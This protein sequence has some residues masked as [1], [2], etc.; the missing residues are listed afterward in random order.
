MNLSE[1]AKEL[2]LEAQTL[3]PSTRVQFVSERCGADE[4]LF[5]E[6][7][8]LLEASEQSETYF[9][10]LSS[11]VSL[12]SLATE[13]PPLPD[14]KLIGHWRLVRLLGRG[15][16]GTVYLAERSDDQFE[17]QA[18]LKLLPFGVDSET[19]RARFLTERQILASLA[20]DNIARLLDGGVTNEGTPYFVMDYV[21]G[22][23]IDEYCA[24][25]ELTLRKRLHLILDVA[26]AVQFAHR[27]LIVH[28]DLKPGNVLVEKSGQVKLLDFGIAKV[29]EP[30]DEPS[31]ATL[32]AQRPVTPAFSSP[33]MLSGAPV[34]VTTDVYSIGALAYLLLTGRR[35]RDPEYK[36]KAAAPRS[37]VPPA[38]ALTPDVS[39]ELDAVL[40]KALAAD[41]RDRYASVEALAADV[42]NYLS[43]RP[44]AAKPASAWYRGRKFVARNRAA[45]GLTAIAAVSLVSIALLSAQ[46]AL[47]SERQAQQIALERDRA[48]E[49]KRFLIEIFSS[50]DPNR[51]ASELTAKELLDAGRQRIA[52]ELADQPALQVD[53]LRAMSDVYAVTR[54]VEPWREALESE[55]RLREALAGRETTEYAEVLLGLSTV[56][57]IAGDWDASERHA[58]EALELTNQLADPT[59]IGSAQIRLG[60]AQHLQGNYDD[61]EANF[62]EALVVFQTA[63][64]DRHLRTADAKMHLGSLMNHRQRF[65]EAH[66]F[67]QDVLTTR[68]QLITGDNSEFS[69][70]LVQLGSVLNKLGRPDEAVDV[71]ERAH[72]MNARLFGEDNPYNNVVVNGLGKVAEDRGDYE[73]AAEHYAEALRVTRLHNDD[74]ANIGIV[75]ANLGKMYTLQER[76]DLALPVYA[77][78]LQLVERFM[79]N[80]WVVGDVRWRYGRCLMET[81][82][83]G[84]AEPHIVAGVDRLIEQ[85]GE[86][87]PGVQ[88]G[89]VVAQSLFERKDDDDTAQKYAAMLNDGA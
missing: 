63:Y 65:K 31:V 53:L 35:P 36:S 61:A 24:Q 18:A 58:M 20:H 26:A 11:N 75:M 3:D 71:Y 40:D 39:S 41:P 55:R 15:G 49:A 10:R 67:L 43:G 79:P 73:A 42:R 16:M 77:E 83:L 80:H 2:F 54:E 78:A 52:D 13:E 88:K 66:D 70:V 8:S 74:N 28:R 22:E 48:E 30:S 23:P 9:Q 1:R 59:L 85:W 45:V 87:H 47:Q 86:E 64:G 84:S 82:D 29:L 89:I 68:E 76:Y 25:R 38:S 44:V 21:D 72:A 12:A 62:R 27:K 51:D 19:A 34:D 33:E 32:L 4:K 69:D 46:S 81:G 6:V 37:N 7:S 60:R 17:Q 50:A 14:N 5:S 56:E 57:D